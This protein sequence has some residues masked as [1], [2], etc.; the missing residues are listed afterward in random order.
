MGA[1]RIISISKKRDARDA[2]VFASTNCIHYRECRD[3]AAFANRQMQCH[4]CDRMQI[5]RDAYRREVSAH[6]I[7]RS[8][9]GPHIVRIDD[10]H[11]LH[12]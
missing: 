11:G 7:Y 4:K 9:P 12:L 10:S 6:S 1:P 2:R 3:E 5:E 8:D